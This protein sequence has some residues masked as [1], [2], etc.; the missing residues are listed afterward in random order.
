MGP[1]SQWA[2]GGC[3]TGARPLRAV[4]ADRL[5]FRA[6]AKEWRGSSSPRYESNGPR[7]RCGLG[8]CP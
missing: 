3:V 6:V 1:P 2:V 7:G 4:G 8:Y 5:G